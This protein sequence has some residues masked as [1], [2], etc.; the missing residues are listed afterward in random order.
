MHVQMCKCIL[1]AMLPDVTQQTCLSMLQCCREETAL[2]PTDYTNLLWAASRLS[3]DLQGSV[4]WHKVQQVWSESLRGW[5]IKELCTALWALGMLK[6]NPGHEILHAMLERVAPHAEELP[7]KH[8]V[9]AIT[10]ASFLNHMP[11][12]QFLARVEEK[13]SRE[14][15]Q[16]HTISTFI[17][18]VL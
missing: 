1:W 13:L 18:L 10:G 2:N 3:V 11:E 7:L 17:P 5:R 9:C 15:M 4:L 12:K 6:L 8:T 16:V 14:F